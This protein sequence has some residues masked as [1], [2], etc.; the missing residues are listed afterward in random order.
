MPYD[1]LP[2]EAD[3]LPTIL[4]GLHE[5]IR[6]CEIHGLPSV[7]LPI[8]LLKRLLS[9]TPLPK[10]PPDNAKTTT[11]TRV[12]MLPLPSYVP[13]MTEPGGEGHR[14]A[15]EEPVMGRDGWYY[16]RHNKK[17]W[18]EYAGVAYVEGRV[19][20]FLYNLHVVYSTHSFTEPELE[21]IKLLRVH[22]LLGYRDPLYVAFRRYVNRRYLEE[23]RRGRPNDRW[24]WLR[25]V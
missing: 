19:D 7:D 22:K 1:T 13:I 14:W 9:E 23:L 17:A 6:N 8:P 16:D 24:V 25:N 12:K 3:P 18:F 5:E 4:T 21:A 2:K 15:V 20:D 11:K 10:S